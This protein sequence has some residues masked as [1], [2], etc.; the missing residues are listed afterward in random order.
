MMSVWSY[1]L[2][3][4]N[5]N[6]DMSFFSDTYISVIFQTVHND[7]LYWA[8]H[9]HTSLTGQGHRGVRKVKL[10]VVFSRLIFCGQRSQMLFKQDLWDSQRW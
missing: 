7:N 1:H 2:A 6:F 5:I 9:L 3:G 8:L 10:Q 4:C